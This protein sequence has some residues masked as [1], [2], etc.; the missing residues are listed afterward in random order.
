MKKWVLSRHDSMDMVQKVEASAG[1][2]LG[3]GKSAQ[4]KCEEPVDG[5]VF[6]NL[7]GLTYVQSEEGYLPFL[8]SQEA[9]DLFPAAT[10]DEGAIRCMLNGADVMRPGIKTIDQWGEQGKVVIVREE[11]KG[12]AIAVGRATVS[13]GEAQSMTKGACLR[14]VHHVGDRYWTIHKQV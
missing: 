2:R 3:L 13:S 5:V 7:D 12:R 9:L 6:E 10:G 8:G 11:K 4:A 1:V 14:N